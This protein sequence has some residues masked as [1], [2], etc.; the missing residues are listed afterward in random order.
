MTAL[1]KINRYAWI[2]L[3]GIIVSFGV[4]QVNLNI[5]RDHA[6]ADKHLR[7]H[8]TIITADDASYLRP[9]ANFLDGNSWKTHDAGR[10]SY[11][12][13]TPGYG[14]I[15]FFMLLSFGTHALTALK[16]FQVVL[17][18]ISVYLLGRSM[19]LLRIPPLV[20]MTALILYAISPIFYG[21]LFYTLTEG[22]TPQLS[23]IFVYL[24]LKA[25]HEEKSDTRYFLLAALLLGFMIIV[26]PALGI[27][28]PALLFTLWKKMDRHRKPL[29]LHTMVMAL[30]LALIPLF[31]WQLRNFIITGTYT[32]LHP[33]YFPEKTGVF[34]P[35]HKAAWNFFK[36]W[37]TTGEQFHSIMVPFWE[38]IV[39]G[40]SD[41]LERQNIIQQIPREFYESNQEK[42]HETLALFRLSIEN[43]IPYIELGK[44]MPMQLHHVEERTI[45]N[46]RKLARSYRRHHPLQYYLLAP[47][48]V[49]EEMIL[50]SNLSLYMF[51]HTF[52]GQP[53]M[54]ALRILMAVFHISLFA[55]ILFMIFSK[56]PFVLKIILAITPLMWI[57]YLAWIQRGIEERYMLPFLAVMLMGLFFSL[58][59]DKGMRESRKVRNENKK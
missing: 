48:S 51:Q 20:S 54:E 50:H 17:F 53:A 41:S 14:L 1:R 39:E 3:L 5:L 4:N 26:R 12:F 45:E 56:R 57:L 16:I 42:V 33:V 32:G 9:A 36:G 47:V 49:L 2:A 40:R 55:G 11:F 30:L 58:H 21:F 7:N 38:A 59:R 34:R 37:G 25:F 8:Q 18:G 31:G 22:I 52:R 15:W 44:P 19:Q 27:W 43:Q 6:D 10:Q 46:F 28:L 23:V 35:P 24:L 29:R 13:R